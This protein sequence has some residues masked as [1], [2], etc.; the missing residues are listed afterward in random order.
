MSQN[1]N[2]LIDLFISNLANSVTH[3]VLEKATDEEN[4]RNH[5]TKE[6]SVSLDIAKRYR[7]KN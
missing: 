5:Y 4:I 6:L 7:E 1:R 2:K 3:K